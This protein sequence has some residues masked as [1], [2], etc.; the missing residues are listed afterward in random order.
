M[1]SPKTLN[2]VGKRAALW[3]VSGL[4]FLALARGLPAETFFVGDP[5]VK[6]IAARHSHPDRPLEIPLPAIGA[7]RVPYV[8][9]FFIVHG[10]HSHAVTSELFPLLSAPFITA[11]GVRGAYVLPALGFFLYLAALVPLS[12]RCGGRSAAAVLLTS[13]LGTPLL[14]YG[15]EFWEHAPAVGVATLGTVWFLGAVNDDRNRALGAGL[16]FGLA[17]LLRPEAAW[18]VVAVLAASFLLPS[19]TP[20]PRA[21]SYVALAAVMTIAPIA[22]Y[23]L[24]HFGTVV[25][26]HVGSQST[27]AAGRWLET[28]LPVLARWFAPDAARASELWGLALVAMPVLGWSWGTSL[29][30]HRAFLTAIALIDVALVAAS[31]PN[32]GGAQWGPRYLLFAFIPAAVL[33]AGFFERVARSAGIAMIAFALGTGLWAQREGYRELR[34]AKRTYAHVLD[35]VRSEV[36]AS[37]YALTDVWWLD[38]VAAAAAGDRRILFVDTP[39]AR[40]DAF[41]RLSDSGVGSVTIFRISDAPGNA[42]DWLRGTCYRESGRR[43]IA[44]RALTAVRAQRTCS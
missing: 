21:L 25:P 35:L 43:E 44:E 36:P 4:V 38:Q 7:D 13:A 22:L 20:G 39:E 27:L 40:H 23:S 1:L 30:Q 28:R 18:F 8:E 32:D 29:R 24:V 37:G 9:P 34:G 15:L 16:L 3:A 41:R 10:D 11:F 42:N 2:R 19:P 6:L 12:S 5:G 33:G 31:A 26:P 14:F 17:I